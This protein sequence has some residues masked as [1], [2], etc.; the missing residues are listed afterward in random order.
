MQAMYHVGELEFLPCGAA[1]LA[2]RGDER[3]GDA[4]PALKKA[5]DATLD[6]LKV[7]RTDHLMSDIWGD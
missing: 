4:L 5:L 2:W 3:V 7:W 1:R 6:E